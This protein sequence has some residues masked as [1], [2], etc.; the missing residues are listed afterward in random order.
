[1][2]YDHPFVASVLGRAVNLEFLPVQPDVDSREGES[3]MC[4]LN[5]ETSL[6]SA[7]VFLNFMFENIRKLYKYIIFIVKHLQYIYL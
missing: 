5:F 2:I 1:M 7:Q 6:E 4:D 3:A